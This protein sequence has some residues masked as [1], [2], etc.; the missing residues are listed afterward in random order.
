MKVVDLKKLMLKWQNKS[1]W[2]P[3]L[4][5]SADGPYSMSGFKQYQEK[6]IIHKTQIFLVRDNSLI[7]WGQFA[8]ANQRALFLL[9]TNVNLRKYLVERW[10]I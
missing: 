3:L 7:K 9:S 6:A 2:M 1:Q 10:S 4:R 8:R 5:D